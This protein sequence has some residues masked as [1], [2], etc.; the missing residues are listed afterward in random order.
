MSLLFK[1]SVPLSGHNLTC[2]AAGTTKR[3]YLVGVASGPEV[4]RHRQQMTAETIQNFHNSALT[5]QV[6]LYCKKHD[7]EMLSDVGILTKSEVDGNGEWVV[8]FR[9][10][11]ELDENIARDNLEM[12]NQLW[13]KINGD[14][15]YVQAT[16]SGFSIEAFGAK[17]MGLNGREEYHIKE[18]DRV[19]V[20]DK[21]AYANSVITPVE[22]EKNQNQGSDILRQRLE[23]QQKKEEDESAF[24][25]KEWELTSAFKKEMELLAR[26]GASNIAELI[27]D[28]AT[29][30]GQLM[31]ELVIKHPD[32]FIDVDEEVET[33]SDKAPD[34]DLAFSAF[35]EKVQKNLDEMSLGKSGVQN[36]VK[37]PVS[38]MRGFAN[39]L[40]SAEK[41]LQGLTD[42]TLS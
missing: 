13:A 15:P 33:V 5:G 25:S 22:K 4:D 29:E 16:E 35:K 9:L 31:G 1:F 32:A 10:F 27:K 23:V 39:M 8:E 6:L 7:V 30:Y 28:L 17:K 12:A 20:V 42:I 24:Y 11:D 14:A 26:S 36:S 37:K 2:K 19:L 40:T 18:I 41:Q 38:V 21:P 3:R 34:T